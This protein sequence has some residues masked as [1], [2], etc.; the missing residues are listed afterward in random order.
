M[1][2]AFI[3]LLSTVATGADA[4][5]ANKKPELSYTQHQNIVFAE[6]DGVGLLMDIFTPT[7][8]SN[9]LAIVDVASGSYF[10]SRD[11]LNDHKK[12]RMFDIFCGKG[13]T[14]FAVRPGSRPKYSLPEMLEN[15]HTGIRW[16]K[17]HAKEYNVDPDRLGLTGASAGGHLCSLA[18]VTPQAADPSARDLLAKF[19]TRVRAVVAFFPPSDFLNYGAKELSPESVRTVS[20]LFGDILFP[21]GIKN[22]TNE[23]IFEAVAK[24]SPARQVTSDA[25]PFLLFHGTA[26]FLVPI[27]QS[28]LFLAALKEKGVPA[29][30]IIKQGGG[31]PWP[32]IHEEVQVAADWFD[33]Q[34]AGK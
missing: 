3:L 24:L 33:S 1:A 16:V 8:A 29:E 5:A 2:W 9:G 34:L 31:H 6:Q 30:L 12:A 17:A 32:T 14:V 13:Y 4:P 20:P 27:K 15:V 21:G 11:K 18:A 7:G 19:D 22:Q 23:E 28:K 10:S 26:D 25:P